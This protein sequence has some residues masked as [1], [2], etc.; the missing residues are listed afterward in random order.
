MKTKIKEYNDFKNLIKKYN[1]NLPS[2]ISFIPANI[3]TANLKE[4]LV[5]FSST[6]SLRKLWKSNSVEINKIEKEGDRQ[7]YLH[8]HSAEWVAPTIFLG[9]ALFSESPNTIS[10][11]LSIVA[12]YVTDLFKGKPLKSTFK[13][14][15]IIEQE[16][17]KKYKKLI[18]EGEPKDMDGLIKVIREIKK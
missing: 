9:V 3:E 12:N 18:F 7:L 2:G 4:E 13:M 16:K 14:E 5:Y 17:D 10:I 8:L 1:F 11:A 15:L 6:K